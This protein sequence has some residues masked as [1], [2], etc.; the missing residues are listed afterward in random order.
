VCSNIILFSFTEEN[1]GDVPD[2]NGCEAKDAKENGYSAQNANGAEE[3]D[4]HVKGKNA[5]AECICKCDLAAYIYYVFSFDSILNFD[6]SFMPTATEELLAR[7]G[8]QLLM[9]RRPSV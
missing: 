5:E 7:R 1:T 3:E 9:L 2:H 4:N 8:S 6:F